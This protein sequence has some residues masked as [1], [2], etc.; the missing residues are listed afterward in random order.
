MNLENTF[1]S[2][3]R[4]RDYTTNKISK[5]N[6]ENKRFDEITSPSCFRCGFGID[7]PCDEDSSFIVKNGMCVEN[8]LCMYCIEITCLI[9]LK[10]DISSPNNISCTHC[11]SNSPTVMILS[12]ILP[13]SL[14]V[15]IIIPFFTSSRDSV[16]TILPAVDF[17][18]RFIN[19]TC[20]SDGDESD[21]CLEYI[22]YQE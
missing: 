8:P 2:K 6:F 14:V 12:K 10:T 4:R 17:Y 11:I 16:L 13:L 18:H 22:D 1:N 3:K 19:T 7:K 15:Q 5:R 21:D 9:C 20:E